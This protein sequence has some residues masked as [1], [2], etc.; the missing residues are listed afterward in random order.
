MRESRGYCVPVIII[1]SIVLYWARC[2]ECGWVSEDRASEAL[3][4]RDC[5][6]HV[7]PGE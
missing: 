4:E 2:T 7:C 1:D 3:A 6:G 5:E